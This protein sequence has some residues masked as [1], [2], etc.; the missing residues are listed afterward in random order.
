MGK[1]NPKV[2]EFIIDNLRI[3]IL[4][5]LSYDPEIKRNGKWL[6]PEI[7]N[8]LIEI[9]KTEIYSKKTVDCDIFSKIRTYTPKIIE[10]ELKKI[11]NHEYNY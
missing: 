10:R 9:R 3:V 11:K 2:E 5:I 1:L 7:R 4:A 6:T 8:L